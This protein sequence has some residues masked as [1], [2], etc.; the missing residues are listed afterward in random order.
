MHC[1]FALTGFLTHW[2]WVK[3][4]CI[5][6]LS[7][8]GSDKG[9][10]PDWRQAI[11]WTNTGILLIGPWGTKFIEIIIEILTFSFMK[12]DFNVSSAKWRPFCLGLNV[13][14]HIYLKYSSINLI[15]EILIHCFGGLWLLFQWVVC[16]YVSITIKQELYF[17]SCFGLNSIFLSILW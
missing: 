9:L 10:S 4:I 6:N 16:M 11:I 2:G 17:K 13:L 3:H 5:G 7:N 1:D 8:I 12:M 14:K 15:S